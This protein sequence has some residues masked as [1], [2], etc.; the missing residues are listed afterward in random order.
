MDK[1]AAGSLESGLRLLRGR[2]AART[3]PTGRECE[4]RREKDVLALLGKEHNGMGTKYASIRAGQ[5]P[6]S[7]VGLQRGTALDGKREAGTKAKSSRSSTLAA[8]SA[9]LFL[10]SSL[11]RHVLEAL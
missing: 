4:V 7:S 10:Y 11:L 5:E 2:R 1:R 6:S 9:I 8:P 3:R